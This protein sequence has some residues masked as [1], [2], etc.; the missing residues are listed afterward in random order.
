M[1]H[2]LAT[3]QLR[4]EFEAWLLEVHWLTS[5]WQEERN[6]FADYPAHLAFQAWQA[7]R[8]ALVVELP[9]TSKVMS[10]LV[11]ERMHREAIEAAGVR[12]KP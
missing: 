10:T 3:D 11:V 6:C 5:E 1:N 12:V 4:K 7:S 2:P 8:A 9:K